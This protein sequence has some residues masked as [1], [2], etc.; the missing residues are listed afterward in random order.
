[1]K[2]SL[3]ILISTDESPWN[4][5]KYYFFCGAVEQIWPRPPRVWGF[6]T[7]HAHTH[8]HTKKHT[9]THT[10]THKHKLKHTH[11]HTVG[12][13]WTS[14]QPVVE[15]ATYM[16]KTALS[17]MRTRD[18]TNRVA[19]V[20]RLRL[21]GHRDGKIF[22][23]VGLYSDFAVTQH[24]AIGDSDLLVFKK[25]ITVHYRNRTAHINAGTVS[26]PGAGIINV[27]CVALALTRF[28]RE[29][30]GFHWELPIV[31]P[32][33]ILF[34]I[35]GPYKA[36]GQD[37]CPWKNKKLTTLKWG[38]FKW[39]LSHGSGPFLHTHSHHRRMFSPPPLNFPYSC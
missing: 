10:H 9:Q 13:L 17:V 1:M 31:S 23:T 36:H 37:I 29:P 34:T 28:G 27:K 35:Q 20:L 39:N 22:C 25:V 33:R 32:L 11:T 3:W 30:R 6:Y 2:V 19:A 26:W 24:I 21:H 8:I 15:A 14:D 4:S 12:L 38:V 7:T 5:P 16:T 18:P